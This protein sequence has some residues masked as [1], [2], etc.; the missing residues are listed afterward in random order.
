MNNNITLLVSRILMAIIFILAG[1]GKFAD[2]AGTAAYIGSVG[3]PAGTLLAWLS[4]IFELVTGLAILVGFRT[5]AVAWALAIFSVVAALFFHNNLGDQ[6]QMVMF[7][8]NLAMAGGFLALSIAGPG[9][10]S[11]DARRA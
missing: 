6:M 5:G 3:L 9:S 1:V 8:K 7:L 2:I 11:L 4:G 10:Y